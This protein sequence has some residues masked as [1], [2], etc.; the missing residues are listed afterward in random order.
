MDPLMEVSK[1]K[2]KDQGVFQLQGNGLAFDEGLWAAKNRPQFKP[3]QTAVGLFRGEHWRGGEDVVN[4]NC[5]A[6]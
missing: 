4:K 5:V 6:L 1:L 2:N 3:T